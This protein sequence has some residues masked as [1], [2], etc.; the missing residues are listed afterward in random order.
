MSRGVCLPQLTDSQYVAAVVNDDFKRILIQAADRFP[1]R[2]AFAKAIGINASRLSRALNTGDFPFN[3]VNCLR[4]AK[5]SGESPTDVLRAAGKADVAELIE[6]LY[7]R[8]AEFT[9]AERELLETWRAATPRAQAAIRSLLDDLVP[10]KSKAAK[11]RG[12]A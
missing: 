11:K 5:L 2:L 3:V 10:R 12:A 4:L 9:V 1:S 6:L 8:E 7:G